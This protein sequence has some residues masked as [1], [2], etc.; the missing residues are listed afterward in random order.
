MLAVQSRQGH[1]FR[2]WR[3]MRLETALVQPAKKALAQVGLADQA[4]TVAMQLAHGARRQLEMAM[5]ISTSPRMLLLDEPLAGM[6]AAESKS[7]TLLLQ[8]LKGKVTILLIE[9][10]MNV[11]FSLADKVSVLVRG[12]VVATG[13]PATVRNSD[14]VRSAYLGEEE[15]DWV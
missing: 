8:S 5:A 4:D 9:H 7:I 1:S 11:V 12:K 15:E 2:F 14:D 6:S 13:D 10:D 3:D